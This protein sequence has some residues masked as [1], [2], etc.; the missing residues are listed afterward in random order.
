MFTTR[1]LSLM[2]QR[3]SHAKVEISS[4]VRMEYVLQMR[5]YVMEMRT[6]LMA[7]MREIAVCINKV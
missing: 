2:L 7:A 1:R 5:G 3:I 4:N 6:V